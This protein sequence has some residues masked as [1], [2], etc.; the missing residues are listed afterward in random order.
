VVGIAGGA[1]LAAGIVLLVTAPSS[2]SAK[3][4]LPLVVP[5]IARD[6]AGLALQARF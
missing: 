6:S 4:T 5:M 3:G 1:M 2:K